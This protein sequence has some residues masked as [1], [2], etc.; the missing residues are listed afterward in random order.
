MVR[1]KAAQTVLVLAGSPSDDH[2]RGVRLTGRC[3]HEL[4]GDLHLLLKPGFRSPAASLVKGM[5]REPLF[6]GF[7]KGGSQ[8]I[9]FPLKNGFP[10]TGHICRVHHTA[11]PCAALVIA[12]LA[13]PEQGDPAALLKRKRVVPVLKHD[14]SFRLGLAG[15]G[16]INLCIKYRF[17]HVWILSGLS[18]F[19]IPR[20]WRERSFSWRRRRRVRSLPPHPPLAL[21]QGD[22]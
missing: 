16:S 3:I 8:H 9:G 1:G 12:E 22:V 15:N 14:D 21:L 19:V 10:D 17:A 20:P 18:S 4:P 13:A 6:V 11:G 5:I 2:H 7:F